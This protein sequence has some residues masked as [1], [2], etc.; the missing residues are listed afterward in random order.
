MIVNYISLKNG[1]FYYLNKLI[2]LNY[3]Q[4]KAVLNVVLNILL[5][6]FP[7]CFVENNLTLKLRVPIC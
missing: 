3:M 2:S 1:T 4:N 7:A 5:H 6:A